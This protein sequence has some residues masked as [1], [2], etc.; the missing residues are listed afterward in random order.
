MNRF[1]NL[2]QN[3]KVLFVVSFLVAVALWMMVIGDRNPQTEN[4]IRDVPIA[5]TGTEIMQDADLKIITVSDTTADVK[6]FGRLSEIH[7]VVAA[8]VTL[9]ADLSEINKPGTYTVP[10]VSTV[11]QTG[12]SV[13]GV[14]PATITV[15]ADFIVQ[16]RR[17]VQVQFVNELPQDYEQGELSLSMTSLTVEG[18]ENLLKTIAKAVAVVD[19]NN[20]TQPIS[21]SYPLKLVDAGG[22]EVVSDAIA[23]SATEVWVDLD[24]LKAKTVPVQV[25]LDGEVNLAE[26]G[27]TVTPAPSSVRIKGKAALID[28]IE[29]IETQPIP[30]SMIPVQ[31][32]TIDTALALPD[33]VTCD[34]EQI[35][36]MFDYTPPET[37][38]QTADPGA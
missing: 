8:D 34:T 25:V 37:D 11:G 1:K 4:V 16:N 24:I 6:I 28:S 32:G 7:Q 31:A 20:I 27:H 3:D 9:S 13:E 19:L 18:P 33:G 21:A 23:V 29:Q 35:S 14:T 10:L 12:V 26:T 38:A 2:F 30:Q 17:E 15:E 22:N 36:V 5:Y